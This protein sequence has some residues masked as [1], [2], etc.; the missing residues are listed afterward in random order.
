LGCDQAAE[1]AVPIATAKAIV[2]RTRLSMT[3]FP[4]IS[5]LQG[6]HPA[7]APATLTTLP[8]KQSQSPKPNR[9][10]APREVRKRS[11]KR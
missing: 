1:L 10:A 7:R 11:A 9:L 5:F 8:A 2:V 3:A 4:L 6:I